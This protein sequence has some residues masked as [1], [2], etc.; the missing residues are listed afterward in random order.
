MTIED[1]RKYLNE[2]K[3]KCFEESRAYKRDILN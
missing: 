1:K 2:L 3:D